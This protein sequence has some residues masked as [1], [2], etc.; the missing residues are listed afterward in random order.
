MIYA[1][2]KLLLRLGPRF[3]CSFTLNRLETVPTLT[4]LEIIRIST[5]YGRSRFEIISIFSIRFLSI[6]SWAQYKSSVPN[7]SLLLFV[8]AIKLT[9]TLST[10]TTTSGF[11]FPEVMKLEDRSKIEVEIFGDYQT[12]SGLRI[13][14]KRPFRTDC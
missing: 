2:V 12:Y 6:S 13:S 11:Q 3:M 7:V 1:E 4:T 5:L 8:S 9:R 10:A 14:K